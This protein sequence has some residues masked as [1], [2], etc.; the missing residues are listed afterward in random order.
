LNVQSFNL[1]GFAGMAAGFLVGLLSLALR[2][3]ANAVICALIFFL[4]FALM[5]CVEK[6]KLTHRAGARLI[7]A[8]VFMFAFPALFFTAGGYRSGMPSF[9]VF[10]I[11]FTAIMTESGRE[12]AAALILEFALYISCCLVAYHYPGTVTPFQTEY[13]YF[14]DVI[15]G[16]AVT[17]VLLTA[18]V[19]L[20]LRIYHDR[21]KRLAELDKLKTEFLQ[22][23]GHEIRNPLLVISLGA[24]YIRNNMETEGGAEKSLSA[25]T[26][27][28]DEAV[29]L[30][31]MIDGMVELA[32]MS[33]NPKNREKTDFAALLRKCAEA[34]RLQAEQ[35]GNVLRVEIS[36]DLPPV[37]ADPEQLERVPVNLLSNAVNA[38][39][40]GEITIETFTDTAYIT[41]RVR[42]TGEGIAPELLPRIFDRGVSGRGGK[43]YGLSIC[44]TVTEAHGGRIW[45]ESEPGK[46]TTVMFTVPVYG[47]QRERVES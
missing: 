2:A 30:G 47:G 11:I 29:R 7:I 20:H 3:T 16:I 19:L 43:G 23:I 35:R 12:R 14:R 24:D 45:I 25:L 15:I 22:D 17:S 18:V 37:Y 39:S 9:F 26:V 28:Q 41:V 46:G 1:L 13:D 42:D 38:V 33:E 27:L 31:R 6:K 5:W 10:A 8:A 36:P 44:K 32:V 34:S 4:A 40:G 21:Q